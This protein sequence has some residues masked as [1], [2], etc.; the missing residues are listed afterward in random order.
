MKLEPL[1]N[2]PAFRKTNFVLL[3]GGW[4][5]SAHTG[6]LLLKPN[7][8]ADFSVEGLLFYPT[9]MAKHIRVWLEVAPDKVLFGTD[10]YPWSE[11]L[12]W[13]ESLYM[14][15]STARQALAIALTGM[16]KDGEL[17]HAQALDIAKMVLRENARKLY[18]LP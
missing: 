17:T 10:A 4:P 3:H 6:A 15:S 1:L 14:S 8:Y 16:W 13:E 5:Y 7:V 18:K 12:G 11:Q 9:E 2:D